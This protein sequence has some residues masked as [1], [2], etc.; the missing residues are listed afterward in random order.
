MQFESLRVFCDLSETKSFTKAAQR[1]HVTQSAVSQTLSALERQFRSQLIER[2]KRNFRLTVEG[3]VLY[4]YSKKILQSYEAFHSRLQSLRGIISGNIHLATVYSIGL[5]EVPAYVRRFL[6]DYP[7][8]NVQVEYRR[9]NHVYQDVLGN[10]AD[11][12]L[13]A[14]PK[15]QTG[16]E[17]MVFRHDLLVLACAPQHPLAKLKVV[18]LKALGGQKMVGFEPDI[19][20]RRAVDKILQDQGV[21][22]EYVAQFDNVETVKRAVEIGAGAAILPEETIR[23][24]VANQ[25]LAAVRL[26]DDYFRPL[27]AI[28]KK[29]KMLSPAMKKF[30]DLL[31]KPL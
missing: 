16:L 25:T 8:V 7:G 17:T 19:P 3:E 22:V 11:L 27:A 21:R 29:G 20:T 1:N 18:K 4:D 2:S 23:A 28:Y 9:A 15:P 14:F 6:K 30:I 10:V 13:V 12:G 26:D 31:K 24:E 5:Y